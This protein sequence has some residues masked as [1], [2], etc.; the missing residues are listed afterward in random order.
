GLVALAA[1]LAGA[2]PTPA[3]ESLV[4]ALIAAP[5]EASGLDEKAVQMVKEGRVAEAEALL[6]K[7]LSVDPSSFFARYHLGELQQRQGK[8]PEALES[9]RQAL[10]RDGGYS[11]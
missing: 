6:R 7:A 5:M 2:L 10:A 1:A 8:N 9:F 4:R 3:R 11:W